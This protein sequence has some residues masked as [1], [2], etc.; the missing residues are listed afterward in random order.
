LRDPQE[1]PRRSARS[2]ET[3]RFGRFEHSV[4]PVDADEDGFDA[5]A[6]ELV[7]D[8]FEPELRAL[9][10]IDPDPERVLILNP[11]IDLR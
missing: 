7:A 3:N 5:A 8:L 11:P 6:G 2:H 10:L 4:E 1:G 9:G